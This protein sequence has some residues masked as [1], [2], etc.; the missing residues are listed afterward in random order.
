MIDEVC[1]D[2]DKGAASRESEAD[3]ARRD[4]TLGL[5]RL[6]LA[7]T[8]IQRLSIE[9]ANLLAAVEAAAQVHRIDPHGAAARSL[10]GQTRG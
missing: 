1:F 3:L 10:P 9:N 5:I 2:A 6:A 8:C 4:V 7:L